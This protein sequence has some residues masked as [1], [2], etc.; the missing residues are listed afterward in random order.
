L[1]PGSLTAMEWSVGRVPYPVTL[2]S[3]SG[4]IRHG[5]LSRDAEHGRLPSKSRKRSA[6]FL[7]GD[8]KPGER[9]VTFDI[10]E[11]PKTPVCR[12]AHSAIRDFGNKLVVHKR[13]AA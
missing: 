12:M 10:P 11:K 9:G 7:R 6:P 1:K 4:V 3:A 5:K 2:P 13:K 8:A